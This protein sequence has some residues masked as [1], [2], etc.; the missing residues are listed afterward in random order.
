MG[1]DKSAENT[2]NAQKIFGKICLPKHKSLEF[3]KKK[4]SSL[5]VSAVHGQDN[6]YLINF[7]F[8]FKGLILRVTWPALG[9]DD[10]NLDQSGTSIQ[11][12]PEPKLV[13]WHIFFIK[14][15]L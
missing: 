3:S 5:W 6:S 13:T 15:R 9:S 2:P 7:E 10:L 14:L 8:C 1:A 12:L 4:K 11:I